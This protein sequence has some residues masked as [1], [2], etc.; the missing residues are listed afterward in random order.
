MSRLLPVAGGAWVLKA[1]E[2]SNGAAVLPFDSRGDVPMDAI[3]ELVGKAR[4]W[5]LQRYVERPLLARGR[6]KTHCRGYVLVLGSP[7]VTGLRN[8]PQDAS[9]S[10]FQCSVFLHKDLVPVFLSAERFSTE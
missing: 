8:Q 7:S 2:S 9:D 4:P 10:E 6:R 1:S 3:R 5:L